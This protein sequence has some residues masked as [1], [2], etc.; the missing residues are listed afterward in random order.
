M[1]ISA[2]KMPGL[3]LVKSLDKGRAE[4]FQHSMDLWIQ[5]PNTALWNGTPGFVMSK[6]DTDQIASIQT[7]LLN[8]MDAHTMEFIKG[9]KDITDEKTWNDWCTMLTKMNYQKALELAQPYLVEF[10]FRQP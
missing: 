9:Q 10:D 5:Y 1:A 8:Y 4:T 7:K 6:E 2:G 3:T